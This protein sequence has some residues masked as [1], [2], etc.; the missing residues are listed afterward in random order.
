MKAICEIFPKLIFNDNTYNQDGNFTNTI[1]NFEKIRNE[2]IQNLF[3][4]LNLTLDLESVNNIV[5]SCIEIT[6]NRNILEY[7]SSDLTILENIFQNL[8]VNLNLPENSN[9]SRYNYKEI[10]ILLLNI[11]RNLIF[12]NMKIPTIAI[13]ENEEDVVNSN[14]EIDLSKVCNNQIGEMILKNL[15]NILKNFPIVDKLYSQYDTT[16]GV[17]NRSIG[18]TR[19]KQLF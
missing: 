12:E 5:N 18:I 2:A 11:L 19:Y 6:E 7:V 15:P 3:G 9:M 8:T 1:P 4:K 13:S 17:I 14:Y 10:L 16:F